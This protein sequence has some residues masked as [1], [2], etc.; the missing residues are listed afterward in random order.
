MPGLPRVT[1]A[2][3][4][5]FGSSILI[6]EWDTFGTVASYRLFRPAAGPD[7]QAANGVEVVSQGVGGGVVERTPTSFLMWQ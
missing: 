4:D 1:P 5:G 6:L 7:R 3:S 2:I